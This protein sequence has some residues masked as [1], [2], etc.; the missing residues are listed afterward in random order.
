L[1]LL[2]LLFGFGYDVAARRCYAPER[3]AGFRLGF[4]HGILVPVTLPRLLLYKDVPIY[5]ANNT[6]RDYKLGFVGGIN[7]CGLLFFGLAFRPQRRPRS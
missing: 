3:E 2:G 6:G 1:V 7:F 5:A 4:L